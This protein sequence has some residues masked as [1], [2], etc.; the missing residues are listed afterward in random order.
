MPSASAASAGP[1]AAAR[2]C[3]T[4]A[5]GDV[6]EGVLSRFDG[7]GLLLE[8]GRKK[9]PVAVLAKVAVV[10]LSSDLAAKLR[11]V[12]THGRLILTD[13]S[14]LLLKAA[15]CEDGATLLRARP[16]STPLCVPL[17]KVGLPGTAAG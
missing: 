12:G 6:L 10:A 16:P 3:G 8:I 5:N 4:A 13:G 9:V 2:C 17:S 1:A 7:K 11:P 14:R 15:A